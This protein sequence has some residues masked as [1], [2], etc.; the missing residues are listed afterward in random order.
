MGY[1]AI[2]VVW[3]SCGRSYGIVVEFFEQYHPPKIKYGP[4]EYFSIWSLRMNR[5]NAKLT[6]PG[7]CL[8][9]T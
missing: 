7:F 5:F 8:G 6:K 2:S 9:S 4:S 1:I 3:N